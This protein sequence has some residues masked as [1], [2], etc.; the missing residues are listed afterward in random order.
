MGSSGLCSIYICYL[1]GLKLA[2]GKFVKKKKFKSGLCQIFLSASPYTL[3][4]ESF[5]EKILGHVLHKFLDNT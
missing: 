4:R 1:I 2:P 3:A 5:A